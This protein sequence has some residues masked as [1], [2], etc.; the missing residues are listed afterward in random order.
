MSEISSGFPTYKHEP[1]NA[2]K[3]SHSTYFQQ[4]TKKN[5]SH[6]WTKPM[7]MYRAFA[8]EL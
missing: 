7:K 1:I 3:I 6:A 8:K 2:D 4:H 5:S